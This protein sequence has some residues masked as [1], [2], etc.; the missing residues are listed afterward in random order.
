[1][2]INAPHRGTMTEV[3]L[4]MEQSTTYWCLP[5]FLS[6]GVWCIDD[7]ASSLTLNMHRYKPQYLTRGLIVAYYQHCLRQH[8]FSAS[9][10]PGKNA[11]KK[12]EIPEDA[13]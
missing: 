8:A 2:T 10:A 13:T 4:S 5:K 6:R 9:Y 7:V 1:M 12:L 3:Y 11:M